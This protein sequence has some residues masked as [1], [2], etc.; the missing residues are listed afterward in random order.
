MTLLHLASLMLFC[1]TV[2]QNLGVCHNLCHT[3]KRVAG[4]PVPC[5]LQAEGI[6]EEVRINGDAAVRDLTAKFDRV[7]LNEV[8]VPCEVRALPASALYESARTASL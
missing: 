2:A 4:S 7:T 3:E 1:W 6:T 5:S 8:C